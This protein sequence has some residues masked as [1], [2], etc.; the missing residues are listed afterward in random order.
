MKTPAKHGGRGGC[1]YVKDR[2]CSNLDVTD[3][4]CN[5]DLK[6]L[7]VTLR[8]NY[9]PREFTNTF[10]C[11][12]YIPPSGN[13]TRAAR[14]ISDSVHLQNKTDTP[15]FI[16]GD[17]KHCGLNKSLPVFCQFV[18]CS[19]RDNTL[20][21]CYGNIKGAYTARARHLPLATQITM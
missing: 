10:V 1:L 19:T 18:Q 5:P 2:W 17:L 4:I 13:A 16:L 12:V 8:P 7:C 11:V 9:L 6:L 3:R 21:K 15:M 20:D 14:Q